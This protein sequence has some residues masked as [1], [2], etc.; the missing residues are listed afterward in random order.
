MLR[1]SFDFVCSWKEPSL[2]A[3]PF[4]QCLWATFTNKNLHR[5]VCRFWM[6]AFAQYLDLREPKIFSMID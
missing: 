2:T 6:D 1:F 4:E 5:I 3:E